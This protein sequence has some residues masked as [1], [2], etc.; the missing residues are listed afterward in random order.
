MHGAWPRLLSSAVVLVGLLCLFMIRLS[1]WVALLARG[2]ASRDAELLVV[3]REVAVLRGRVAGPEPGWADRAVIAV[4]ARL[5]PGHLRLRRIVTPG[6]VPAW[7]RPVVQNRRAC[8]DT[9]GCPP[10]PGGIR[11]LARRLAG[12]DPGRGRRRVRGGLLGP[13]HGAGAG[14]RAAC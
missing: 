9:A 14:A 12:L 11:G 5:L 13:G 8:P 6:A 7:R 4:L 10:V 3:R 2:G 1:G